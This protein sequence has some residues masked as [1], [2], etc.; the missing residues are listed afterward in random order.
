MQLTIVPFSHAHHLSPLGTVLCS[1]FPSI[2]KYVVRFEGALICGAHYFELAANAI[3]ILIFPVIYHL[4][5]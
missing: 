3:G 4:I 5:F 2:A 1:T